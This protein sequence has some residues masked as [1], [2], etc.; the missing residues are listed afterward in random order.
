[1]EIIEEELR[2][3]YNLVS[4]G[5]DMLKPLIMAPTVTVV[6]SGV[7]SRRLLPQELPQF[8]K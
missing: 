7:S 3:S 4:T 8:Y 6:L 2:I 1:M 5:S